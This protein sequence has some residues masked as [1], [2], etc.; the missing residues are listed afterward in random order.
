[1]RAD[2][3]RQGRDRIGVVW[4]ENEGRGTTTREEGRETTTVAER[5]KERAAEDEDKSSQ[6]KGEGSLGL[7]RRGE[8]KVMLEKECCGRGRESEAGQRGR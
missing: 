4:K 8:V 2:H 1:M 6:G 3:R 5:V 7:T